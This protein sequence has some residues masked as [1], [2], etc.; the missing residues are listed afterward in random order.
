MNGRFRRRGLPVLLA[1]GGVAAI[2]SA[3]LIDAA[4]AQD[5]ATGRT[6]A[7]GVTPVLSPRRVPALLARPIAASRLAAK[8]DPILAAAGGDTCLVVADGATIIDRNGGTPLAPASNQKLLVGETA[9]AVLGADTT[10]TTRFAAAGPIGSDGTLKGPLWMIGGGD[11][12]IDTA[13]YQRTSRHGVSPHTSMERIA[14]DLVAKGLKKIDGGITGDESRYD[15][16]RDVP[17][18]PDRYRSD[19]QVGPLSGL[20]VNDAKGYP[21][22]EATGT[23]HPATDPAAYAAGV[24]IDLLRARGVEVTGGPASGKAP[25]G[26]TTIAE[27]PSL[28]VSGIVGEM[29]AWSDNNTAE[30]LLK[31]LGRTRD[32]PTTAGGIAVVEQ[33]LRKT[34]VDT[35][36]QVMVDGSGLDP[37]NRVTCRLLDGVLQNDGPKS[38]LAG[39]LPV[40]G[41]TGTLDD[42]FRGS[43]AAGKV[44]AKTGTLRDVSA[45]SGWVTTDRGAELSFAYV[46]N[47]PNRRVGGADERRAEQLTEA[48]LSYP[49]A[50]DPATIGPVTTPP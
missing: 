41:K 18:W 43:P 42:R 1:V 15:T 28:P 40:A 13:S 38:P 21:A 34:G 48:M 35:E 50:P 12:L 20:S 47:T 6:A 44:R 22:G 19:N 30:L 5:I 16:V 25:G 24:L 11:P 46:L 23:V 26:L 27:V 45:L 29:L 4:G 9:L 32:T 8:L 3:F 2:G 14:D 10:F 37:T 33:H 36:G 49:D 31:E 17:S 39:G 7:A